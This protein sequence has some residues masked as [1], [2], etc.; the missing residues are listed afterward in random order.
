MIILLNEYQN[1]HIIFTFTSDNSVIQVSAKMSDRKAEL[2]RKKERLRQMR[3]EKEKRKRE[4]EKLDAETAAINLSATQSGA[5][6]TR[7]TSPASSRSGVKIDE[8][9]LKDIDTI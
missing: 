9:N 6:S 7:G 5:S 1:R 4:K 8:S 2:E 3:E